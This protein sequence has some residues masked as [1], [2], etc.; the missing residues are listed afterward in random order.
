MA[1]RKLP[2]P[3]PVEGRLMSIPATLPTHR[4][5]DACFAGFLGALAALVSWLLFARGHVPSGGLVIWLCLCLPV[6]AAGAA[7]YGARRAPY[8][9]TG[10]WGAARIICLV[11]PLLTG[12]IAPAPYILAFFGAAAMAGNPW[13]MF[14]IFKLALLVSLASLLAAFVVATPVCL[15]G[16]AAFHGLL[17]LLGPPRAP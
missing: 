7:V 3:E 1:L 8:G 2:H 9:A 14:G 13:A 17:R 6:L 12:I 16:V 4:K 11:F 10:Y 15:L 5:R